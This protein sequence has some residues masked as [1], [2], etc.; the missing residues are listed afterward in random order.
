MLQKSIKDK[1]RLPSEAASEASLIETFLG[2]GYERAVIHTGRELAANLKAQ[3]ERLNG[4]VFSSSE[5]QTFFADSI[6]KE[7]A[8]IEDKAFTIQSDYT[9]LLVRDDGS[10][11]NIRLI[12][13]KNIYNNTLQVTNQYQERKA[14]SKMRAMTLQY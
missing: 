6:A 2:Q 10:V 12:D 1:R 3:L 11:C 14:R 7:R 8:W 13:K 4:I 5:W 9:K